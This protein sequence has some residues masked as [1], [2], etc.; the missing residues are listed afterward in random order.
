M[1]AIVLKVNLPTGKG[2]RRML[3]G[4]RVRVSDADYARLVPRLAHDADAYFAADAERKVEYEK[5]NPDKVKAF[6]EIHAARRAAAKRELDARAEAKKAAEAK[7]AAET[8]ARIDKILANEAAAKKAAKA[9][10]IAA[11]KAADPSDG[12]K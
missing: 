12:N 8:K 1:R 5:A 4:Q 2:N 11:K 3:K 7:R 9:A 10:E 6:R